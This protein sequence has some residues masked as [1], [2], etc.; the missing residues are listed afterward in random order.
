MVKKS[1]LAAA[2]AAALAIGLM[3]LPVRPQSVE[4]PEAEQGPE[5]IGVQAVGIHSVVL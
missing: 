5:I 4:A 3:A 2:G 1:F